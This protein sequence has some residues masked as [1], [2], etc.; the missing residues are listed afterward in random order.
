[1]GVDN[2]TALKQV[3]LMITE[4][5]LTQLGSWRLTAVLNVTVATWIGNA[6]AVLSGT[7]GAVTRRAQ[8][9]GYSRTAVYTH[10]QRVVHAVVSEQAGGISYD[11]LWQENE[12]L[13]AENEALWQAWSE[14]E[15]LSEAKQ[16][17]FAG[18]GCAMGLSLSQIVT[19][20]AIVLPWGAVPS[21]AMVGRWVQAA[22]AQ[23]GRLLV[24]LDLACQ[25]RVRV[26]CLDEIFL[27]RGPVLMAIEP[28]SMAWMVG[29][30][31]PDRCGE[32]WREVLTHWPSLEHVIA[33]G[34]QGLE[35]GVKLANAARCAQCEAAEPIPKPA[36]TMGL[37][38]LHTH[39]ALA[40]VLPRP[41]KRAARQLATA[42]QAAAKVA[43][44]KRQGRDPRGVSG[45]AGRAGRQAERLLEPAGGPPGAL[46]PNSPPPF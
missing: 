45:V 13:K 20:L 10:A 35:R 46:A 21:R 42:R 41:W 16:R 6:A 3:S 39:R 2:S 9:S 38:V 23:A 33:D 14:A 28:T 18:S 43:R 22:A 4:P 17:A 32:S 30:R 11:A 25:A 8:Q 37:D 40:R 19:L 44:Y 29:Q 24:V 1:M 5:S 27:H 31:G 15:A 36:M 26:L 12:R 34:G 7:W